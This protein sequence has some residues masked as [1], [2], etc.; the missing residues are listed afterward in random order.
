[1]PLLFLFIFNLGQE[2][3]VIS[4]KFLSWIFV[5]LL[6]LY[7][8]CIILLLAGIST[9]FMGKYSQNFIW[10]RVVLNGVLMQPTVQFTKNLTKTLIKQQLILYYNFEEFTILTFRNICAKY[11]QRIIATGGAPSSLV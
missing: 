3:T 10:F 9:I 2:P 7:N 4:A 8:A 5:A 6:L 11:L 1:L